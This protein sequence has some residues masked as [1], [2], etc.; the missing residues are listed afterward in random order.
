MPHDLEV[1]EVS[2]STFPQP[3]RKKESRWHEWRRDHGLE[4]QIDYN[5]YRE[6]SLLTITTRGGLK[7]WQLGGSSNTAGI[8]NQLLQG[9]I[10]LDREA[11]WQKLVGSGQLS[12]KEIGDVDCAIWDLLGRYFGQPVHKLLGGARERMPAYA[13]TPF[14]WGT[15]DLYADHAE[16]CLRNGYRAYKIHPYTHI[17][18]RTWQPVPGY[19]LAR[20]PKPGSPVVHGFPEAD[21][22]IC[23]AVRARV[24]DQM[25]LMLDPHGRYEGQPFET[26]CKVAERLGQLGFTWFEVP[27]N[28]RRVEDYARLRER[29][30]I[31]ILAPEWSQGGP[32]IRA[33]WIMK[34]ASDMTRTDVAHQ[35]IT[36]AMKTQHLAEAHRMRCEIHRGGWDNIHLVASVPE[37]VTRFYERFVHDADDLRESRSPL[38]AEDAIPDPLDSTG[39][40]SPPP[41]PGLGFTLIQSLIEEEFA[42]AS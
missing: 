14:D 3:I 23:E 36:G 33:H 25:E 9:A 7:G 12:D 41:G 27:F 40:V 11:C 16:I 38:V 10:A 31:P 6:A 17:D 4:P 20:R 5:D 22:E 15:P 2:F 26:V 1:T 19:D 42:C 29:S 35:G 18:P 32:Q 30:P 8:A 39:Q 34:G 28:E 24:G 37:S 13:S 21:L